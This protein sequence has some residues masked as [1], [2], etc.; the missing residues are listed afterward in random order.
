MY[1][2]PFIFK[3]TIQIAVLDGQKI[4]LNSQIF[5][6][7]ESVKRK[8][9]EQY[10]KKIFIEEKKLREQ[11][12]K[13]KEKNIS[14]FDLKAE[15]ETLDQ[16]RLKLEKKNHFLKLKLRNDIAKQAKKIEEKMNEIIDGIAKNKKISLII[17]TTL[18]DQKIIFYT[19]QYIDITNEVINELNKIFL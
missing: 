11:Y 6:Q 13:L 7:L 17:N 15:K 12:Q 18:N 8:K 16:K 3:K 4:K 2:T 19:T 14:L 9:Y 5:L 1:S 10:E